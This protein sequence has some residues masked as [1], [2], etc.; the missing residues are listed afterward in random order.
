MQA[1][2]N[3][4]AKLAAYSDTTASSNPRLKH[5]DWL[6]DIADV[7]VADPRSEVYTINSGSSK[8][9]FD[10]TLASTVDNTTAFG[11]AL[12]TLD[13]ST[14][15]L[16][17]TGGTAPGFRTGRGLTL[18]GVAITFT[19]NSNS[20]VTVT[21]PAGPDFTALQVG[22]EVFVPHTTT[23]DSANVLSV[24]NAGY[25]QV[26]G[27]SSTTNITLIRLA[28]QDFQGISQTVTLT[29]NSQFRGYSQAGLQ[30]GDKINLQGGFA[31]ASRKTYEV[32]RVTDLFVEFVST[33]PLASE[34]SV[35]PTAAG[36]LFFS[37]NKKLVYIETSQ[38]CSVR[39]NG[40]T[41]DSQRI[42]PLD[43]ANSESV[44]IYFRIG[45]TWSLSVVNLSGTAAN[46]M[47]VHCE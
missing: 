34:T 42:S 10:G 20:T 24:L 15:R 16:T 23:G 7:S 31:L 12:S 19:V 44:G 30:T 46:V 6:R 11:L 36:I 14:Y 40:D 28:G 26:L 32:L 1:R 41:S 22:D 13:D 45:P 18:S 35:L 39:V 25:W 4:T 2:L 43:A 38:E 3:F 8:T 5:V 9:V 33:V 37:E 29:S 17:H 27:K 47:I 21:V